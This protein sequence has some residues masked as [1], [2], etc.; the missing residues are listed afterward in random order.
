MRVGHGSS[1]TKQIDAFLH[2]HTLKFKV[3]SLA[4]FCHFGRQEHS[5]RSTSP[6]SPCPSIFL[7]HSHPTLLVAVITISLISSDDHINNPITRDSSL[8]LERICEYLDDETAKRRALFAFSR[9]SKIC[10]TAAEGQRFSR[11]EIRIRDPSELETTMKSW[12][13][14][15]AGERHRHV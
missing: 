11:I 10:S 9:T 2:H 1:D 8:I 14:K 12:N 5:P 3:K 6:P 7:L 13:V 15:L 4:Y